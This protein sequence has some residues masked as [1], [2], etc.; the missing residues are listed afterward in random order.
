MSRFRRLGLAVLWTAA[1]AAGLFLPGR[2]VPDVGPAL[3]TAAHVTFFAGF[4]ALWAWALPRRMPL[5]IGGALTLAVGTE[6][7]Q[8]EAVPGRDGQF[9]DLWADLS[10]IALGSGL[11]WVLVRR[12]QTRR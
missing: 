7:F 10:G 2:A 5:V 9:E 1:A 4:V 3:T 11:A 12:P 8:A 6:V